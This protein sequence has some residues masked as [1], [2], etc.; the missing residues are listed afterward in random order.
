MISCTYETPSSDRFWLVWSEQ[1]GVPMVKHTTEQSAV[2]EARRL[3][4]KHRERQFYVLQSMVTWVQVV[5]QTY[6]HEQ[7]HIP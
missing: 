2:D 5:S 6:L 4:L 1:G 3:A 7:K